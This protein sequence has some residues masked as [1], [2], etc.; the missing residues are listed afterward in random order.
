MAKET[1][2]PQVYSQEF[3]IDRIVRHVYTPVGEIRYQVRWY[4][5]SPENNTIEPTA[6]PP[7]SMILS[8]QRRTPV[9]LP[10]N[11]DDAQVW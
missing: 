6:H 2:E 4:G 3:V 11:L 1:D 9:A 8:Y 7:R 10:P 5:Y